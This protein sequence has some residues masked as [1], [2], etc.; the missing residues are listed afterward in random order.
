[1]PYS[2]WRCQWI[3][4][5]QRSKSNARCGETDA[6]KGSQLEC[7][8][9]T[10]GAAGGVDN[11]QQA[12]VSTLA[13]ILSSEDFALSTVLLDE[14]AQNLTGSELALA[15]RDMDPE[16][17]GDLLRSIERLAKDGGSHEI[18]AWARCFLGAAAQDQDPSVSRPALCAIACAVQGED[19]ELTNWAR[20]F[21]KASAQTENSD[22]HCCP[23]S[24]FM[25]LAQ[26]SSISED[27]MSLAKR[28]D[29]FLSQKV[30]F[31]G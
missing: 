1:M 20:D 28:K 15:A 25:R 26:D 21:M 10:V 31:V 3:A 7:W 9:N 19:P 17:R 8:T 6:P 27:A 5:A 2:E 11:I 13:A 22:H 24:S 14:L 12:A 29:L 16:A 4:E 18:R 30:E 23:V